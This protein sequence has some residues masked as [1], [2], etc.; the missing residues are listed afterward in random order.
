MNILL[1]SNRAPLFKRF[2]I[3]LLKNRFKSFHQLYS[4]FFRIKM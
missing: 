2:K 3:K 1:F 4:L